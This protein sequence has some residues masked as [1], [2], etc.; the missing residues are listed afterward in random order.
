MRIAALFN[1]QPF[2]KFFSIL[3]LVATLISHIPAFLVSW[4]L[5]ILAATA[6]T[7]FFHAE[8]SLLYFNSISL[9]WA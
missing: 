1:R 2:L 5:L 6:Y 4:S 8:I 3:Q 9:A 7:D